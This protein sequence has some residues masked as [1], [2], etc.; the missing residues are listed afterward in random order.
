MIPC[1][2]NNLDE[3]THAYL[4]SLSRKDVEIRFGEQLWAL[5]KNTIWTMTNWWNRKH[6]ETLTVTSMCS[7][8]EHQNEAKKPIHNDGLS[9]YIKR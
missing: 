4:H 3:E 1:N 7:V 2:Y 6:N 8:F 9:L 5:P